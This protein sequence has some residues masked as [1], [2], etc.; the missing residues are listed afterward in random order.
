[1]RNGRAAVTWESAR[2]QTIV[3]D[4]VGTPA[5]LALVDENV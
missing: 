1:V 2:F 4:L 3:T 5:E